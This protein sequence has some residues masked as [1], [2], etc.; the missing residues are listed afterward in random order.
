[1]SNTTHF[2]SVTISPTNKTASFTSAV[3][4]SGKVVTLNAA[5]GLTATLPAATGS[6][7]D[8]K[9]F[10][11]TTVTS[12][13]ITIQ[14]DNANDTISGTALFAQDAADTA[15]L[16]ETAATSDTITLNGSTT[17]GILGDMVELIDVAE[18][19]WFVRITGSAT[20]TEATPF[21]AA[22]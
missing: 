2:S 12:N 10:L 1:M 17:G 5:A 16:F 21:S 18:N 22:V 14:V 20:G 7:K 9:F 11:G 13:N 8:Y 4:E 6:G 3:S 15:V 19:K